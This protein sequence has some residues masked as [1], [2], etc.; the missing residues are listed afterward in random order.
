[1]FWDTG[2]ICTFLFY[3]FKENLNGIKAW[4][5]SSPFQLPYLCKVLFR[6]A[7]SPLYALFYGSAWIGN[8]STLY[9]HALDKDTVFWRPENSFD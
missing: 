7:S 1:M 3:S 6:D 8:V 4:N 9:Q 5:L 2:S